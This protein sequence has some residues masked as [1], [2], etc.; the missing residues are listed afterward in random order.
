MILGG[1]LN[2]NNLRNIS[3]I[4]TDNIKESSTSSSL[5]LLLLIF[6]RIHIANLSTEQIRQDSFSS[7]AMNL[8]SHDGLSCTVEFTM[9]YCEYQVAV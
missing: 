9:R 3:T 7:G 4:D 5:S 8:I 6:N 1:H 2:I